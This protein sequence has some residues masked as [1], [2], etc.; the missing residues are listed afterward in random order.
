M[1]KRKEAAAF[2]GESAG[3]WERRQV[4]RSG[5]AEPCPVHSNAGDAAPGVGT[6]TWYLILGA[7]VRSLLMAKLGWT[8]NPLAEL[9]AS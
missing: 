3:V 2:R 1:V 9:S 8:V 4:L 7:I 5:S 6:Q